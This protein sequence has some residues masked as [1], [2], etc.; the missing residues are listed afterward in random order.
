MPPLQLRGAFLACR[1]VIPGQSPGHA[2]WRPIFAASS[3]G[4]RCR[5]CNCGEVA[6]CRYLS[7]RHHMAPFQ[8]ACGRGCAQVPNSIWGRGL[9]ERSEFR[10]PHLRD[11]GKGTRRATPGRPWFWVLLPKQKDLVV[12]GRNP[13][14]TSRPAVI[15]D[16]DRGSRVFLF[17]AFVKITTLDPLNSQTKCNTLLRCCH[18]TLLHTTHP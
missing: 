7:Q 5:H 11:R 1:R 6:G 14:S 10:S 2:S 3:G 17:P 9:S 12:R 4:M 18:G 16:P 8:G 15:P 13:A